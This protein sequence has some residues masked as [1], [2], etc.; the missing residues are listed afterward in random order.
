MLS[1][2]EEMA[3]VSLSADEAIELSKSAEVVN[4]S[5]GYENKLM[6]IDARAPLV[7]MLFMPALACQKDI[8]AKVLF[9]V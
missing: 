2:R 8:L 4:I 9:A 7:S 1:V 3:L 6:L 5:L